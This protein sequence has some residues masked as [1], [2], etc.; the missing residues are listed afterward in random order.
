M[1]EMIG[2]VSSNKTRASKKEPMTFELRY[3]IRSVVNEIN[4]SISRLLVTCESKERFKAAKQVIQ[5]LEITANK[6][7]KN[8]E[9]VNL[10]T[11]RHGKLTSSVYKLHRKESQNSL[12]LYEMQEHLNAG[13]TDY[14]TW[15]GRSTTRSKTSSKL[16]SFNSLPVPEL[17]LGD[18][19]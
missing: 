15:P 7:S 19:I 8:Q 9:L 11:D 1:D 14:R 3:C 18:S 12:K 16:T 4:G 17:R 5:M 2:V 6:T 10:L 13:T